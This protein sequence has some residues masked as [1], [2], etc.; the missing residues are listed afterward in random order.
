MWACRTLLRGV[1]PWCTTF[2]YY[3]E[4]VI[5]SD[6]SSSSSEQHFGI[7]FSFSVKDGGSGGVEFWEGEWLGGQGGRGEKI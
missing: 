4:C 5:L 2:D 7:R 1:W 6:F 3:G